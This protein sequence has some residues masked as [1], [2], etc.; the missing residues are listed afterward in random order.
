MSIIAL[1]MVLAA[2]AAPAPATTAASGKA[3][4]V[5]PSRYGP[6]L[7]DGKGRALY[8]FTKEKTSKSRCYGDCARAWP[9]FIS[10]GKPR[11]GKGADQDLLGT[12]KR[13]NG[14]RQVTY[15]GHPLYYYVADTQ[16]G[17][18]TCQDVY[19]FGG[20]WLV[21]DRRGRAVH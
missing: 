5:S 18:I 2:A 17:Q 16:A 11:A 12:T 13:R 14:K 19:E 20:T 6:V 9:P 15:N 3:V 8:L 10:S 7:F 1:F 4:K 21:V